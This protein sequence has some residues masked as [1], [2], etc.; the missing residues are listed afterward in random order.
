VC[1]QTVSL[2]ARHLEDNGIPTVLFGCARDIVEH[3]G[4]P[5]FV[6]SDFPLGNPTGRPGDLD[7]QRAVLLMGL[8]LLVSATAPGATVQ[9][10][11]V[12]SE[13]T[14]WKDK[15]FTKEQPFQ[16]AE[17]TKK[18]LARKQAYR[19]LKAAGKL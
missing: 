15:V 11:Y 7:M 10:P 13:G 4:V 16:D 8:D 9:T 2:A 18:W 12:W 14:S 19:E 6:F 5:R 17:T 3:C 1:H